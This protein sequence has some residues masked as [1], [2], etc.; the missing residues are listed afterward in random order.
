MV[1][2]EKSQQNLAHHFTPEEAVA[3]GGNRW[4][5]LH[6]DD[7]KKCIKILFP[8]KT[9]KAKRKRAVWYKK[10][11][12]LSAFDDNIQEHK[13]LSDL[14]KRLPEAAQRHF[15]KSYGF[16]ET[17]LGRAIVVDYFTDATGTP[18]PSL[19]QL[20]DVPSK[21][22]DAFFAVVQTHCIITRDFLPHNLLYV[23]GRIVMID[24]LGNSDF[25]PIASLSRRWGVR[26][27]QRKIARFYEKLPNYKR[28]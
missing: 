6:P 15:P 9:A 27:I 10:L 13:A 17:N 19:L 24:G 5:F 11:R 2:I 4:V 28:G 23:D 1:A 25:I 18:S 20:K 8:E 14:S 12:P 22:L 16:V 21:A 3:K 26:K 7:P